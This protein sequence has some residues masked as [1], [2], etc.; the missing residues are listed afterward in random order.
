MPPAAFLVALKGWFIQRAYRVT[1]ELTD[2][3][4]THGCLP[5]I[6]RRAPPRRRISRGYV[7]G[8]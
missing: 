4:Q 1:A 5:E 2:Y 6:A 3:L 8:G 7:E